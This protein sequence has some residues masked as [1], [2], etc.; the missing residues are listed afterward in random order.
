MLA[1]RYDE[2][3]QQDGLIHSIVLPPLLQLMGSVEGLEV[4]DLACGNGVVAR[5]LAKCGA[6]LVGVDLSEEMLSIARRY[7]KADPLGIR[8]QYDDAHSLE[9]LA[10]MSMD[11]VVCNLA[12]TDIPEPLA[13]AAQA[14]H[15]VLRP[16]GIFVYCLPHPCF[17]APGSTWIQPDGEERTVARVEGYFREGPWHSKRQYSGLNGGYHRMLS[18]LLNTLTACGLGFESSVEPQA[19]VDYKPGYSE[20]PVA[21]LA[22][23]RKGRTP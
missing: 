4:C 7:E 6:S 18:T 23:H 17:Q 1:Q 8:F 11:I 9:T 12:L 13:A 19:F 5:E 10:D 14:V 16:G 22:R 2:L 20:C 3:V 21:W 15:R